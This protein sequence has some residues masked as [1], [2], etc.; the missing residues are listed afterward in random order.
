[1]VSD[2]ETGSIRLSKGQNR[3]V[4]RNPRSSSNERYYVIYEGAGSILQIEWSSNGTDW[5]NAA[6]T[7]HNAAG[8]FHSFDAKISDTGSE[9]HVYVAYI[10]DESG[11]VRVLNY[12]RLVIS[13][14]DDAPGTVGS[15]SEIA[16]L[17]FGITGDDLS[18]SISRVDSGYL[19]VV[20]T[21]DSG[22]MGNIFRE[23]HFIGSQESTGPES[24]TWSGD[25]LWD[26]PSS[27]MDNKDKGEVWAATYQFG[28]GVRSG[29]GFLVCAR[30]PHGSSSTAYDVISAVP[31]W[32]GTSF[33]NTTKFAGVT[34]F[35][36]Q[37]GLHGVSCLV[38][39]NDESH[40]ITGGRGSAIDEPQSRKSASAGEDDWETAVSVTTA[41]IDACSL[42]IDTSASP[43]ELY[44]FYHDVADTQ[45]FH[46]KTS[47]VDT[48]SWGTE[49]TITIAQDITALSTA[50]QDQS[51]GIHIAGQYGTTVFYHEI[52]LAV[53]ITAAEMMAAIRP[54]IQRSTGI[55]SIAHTEIRAIEA[56]VVSAYTRPKWPVAVPAPPPPE[57]FPL[58][59]LPQTGAGK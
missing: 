58:G 15:E 17:T 28:S 54:G 52:S 14:T 46:Y 33:S 21:T 51:G 40:V 8:V 3:I 22:T 55:S 29:N 43:E 44:A 16:T 36:S 9:L 49:Q 4:F 37:A 25:T 27:D 26:D 20:Y 7:I 31:E 34:T 38:D 19:V 47:P 48:I 32:N 10:C 42:T 39:S 12:R 18:C 30:V 41:D 2:V 57:V 59:S 23:T 56:A 50:E 53:P 13:D 45:D 5:T 6:T 24:P 11:G 1:M 35:G